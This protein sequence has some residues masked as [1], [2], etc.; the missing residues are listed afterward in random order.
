MGDYNLANCVFVL[1][2]LCRARNALNIDAASLLS[3]LSLEIQSMSVHIVF[4][5]ILT[6]VVHL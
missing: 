5:Y 6:F 1:T 2:G 4:F 3:A